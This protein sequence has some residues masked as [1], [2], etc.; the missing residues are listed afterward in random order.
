MNAIIFD[1]GPFISLTLNNL[2]NLVKPLEKKFNGAFYISKAV[3]G[4]L[5]EK[6]I[7][8]KKFEFEALQVL[9]YIEK[10]IIKVI[11]NKE[12]DD[13]SVKLLDLANHI[14]KAKDNFMQVVH[15]G[16]ISAVAACL[17]LDSNVL[18][19]DE[20]TLRLLIED[21]KKLKN[22]LEHK[23]HTRIEVNSENLKRFT[24]EV[25]NIKLIRSI[26]LVTLAYEFGLLEQYVPNRPDGNK[27]LLESVLWGVK[28]DGCSVSK[29]EIEQIMRL[30]LKR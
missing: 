2:L 9:N 24:E 5:V 18:V 6:P 13:K 21:P 16:E 11:D 22:I 30:E 7:T 28:L 27:I 25:K 29:R 26:E 12:I 10:G 14:F 19:V 4:E 1:A 23:L 17:Y 15:Y 20:R 3:R 8:T